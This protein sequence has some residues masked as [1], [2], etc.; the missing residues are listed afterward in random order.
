MA[1]PAAACSAERVQERL[2]LDQ[3][4]RVEAL[5]E[6]VVDRSQEVERPL[7][8]TTLGPEA[9]EVAGDAEL[10]GAGLALAGQL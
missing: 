8:L 4:R 6:P 5:G 3:V 10:S 7:P 2:G 1:A 9:G